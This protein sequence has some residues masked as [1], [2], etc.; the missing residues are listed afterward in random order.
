[1]QESYVHRPK[2]NISNFFQSNLY[3]LPL[4]KVIFSVGLKLK[5]ISWG[6]LRSLE[7]GHILYKHSNHPTAKFCST[8][9]TR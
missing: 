7:I 8:V 9:G 1:M 2:R 3:H 4:N 6:G 5:E